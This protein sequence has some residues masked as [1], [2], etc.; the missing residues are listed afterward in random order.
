MTAN[1]VIK[2]NEVELP[3]KLYRGL[4]EFSNIEKQTIL[5]NTIKII[6]VI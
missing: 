4:F 3:K 1:T 5:N 6:L 2:K